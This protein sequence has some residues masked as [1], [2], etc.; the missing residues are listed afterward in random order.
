MK[1]QT[2]TELAPYEDD[3]GNSIQVSGTYTGKISIKF[4]GRNNR[5]VV[6]PGARVGRLTGQFDGNDGSLTIGT[7]H[8]WPGGKWAP[9]G[10]WHFR[11]GEQSSIVIGE[12]V[13]CTNSCVIS[14]VEGTTVT[15]GDDCMLAADCQIRADDAHAI[16]DVRSGTRVNTSRSI[17][18]EDHVWL[19]VGTMVLGGASIGSGSVTGARAVITKPVPNN[20][21]A[22][23]NP[24]RIVR[25]DIAWERPHLSLSDPPFRPD[26]SV[27]DITRSAWRL[28]GE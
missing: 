19:G 1:I 7:H 11:L 18:I 27:I 5:V 12:D 17:V 24:A 22:A 6:A 13:S 20:A 15:L 25:R 23:G 21:I 10:Q 28:T 4:R 2:I 3:R 9:A 26:A 8:N 14:A 16:Y